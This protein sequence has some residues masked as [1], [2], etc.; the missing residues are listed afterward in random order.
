MEGSYCLY[1]NGDDRHSTFDLTFRLSAHPDEVR[2]L[3]PVL[4]W[5]TDKKA[6]NSITDQPRANKAL[7]PTA[8]ATLSPMLFASPTRQLVSTL[9]PAPAVGTALDV[10]RFHPT[11]LS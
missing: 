10:R 11:S 2:Q 9:I 6:I 4:S 1:V 3:P 7:V 8:K 5:D